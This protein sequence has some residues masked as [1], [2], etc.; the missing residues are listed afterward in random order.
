M[1]SSFQRA[2]GLKCKFHPPVAAV[3]A[4][5]RAGG[6][7]RPWFCPSFVPHLGLSFPCH[8][9]I[10]LNDQ[11]IGCPYVLVGL[12]LSQLLT[13]KSVVFIL[14]SVPQ[15]EDQFS[16]TPKTISSP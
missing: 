16:D 2:T 13:I 6:S 3:L 7:R 8:V 1:P 14:K 4:L 10:R 15:L 11:Q 12:E 5:L 9:W